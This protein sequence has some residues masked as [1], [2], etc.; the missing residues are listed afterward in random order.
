[1]VLGAIA[2]QINSTDSTIVT[3]SRFKHV[4]EVLEC[5][6]NTYLDSRIKLAPVQ[7]LDINEI[8]F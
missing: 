5:M 4:I 6:V 7:K 3:C 8:S 2:L 1:M